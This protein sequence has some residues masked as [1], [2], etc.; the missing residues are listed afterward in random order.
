MTEHC[1]C[2]LAL[3]DAAKQVCTTALHLPSSLQV[4]EAFIAPAAAA[5]HAAGEAAPGQQ[6]QQQQRL[7]GSVAA[8]GDMGHTTWCCSVYHYDPTRRTGVWR[9]FSVILRRWLAG[10]GR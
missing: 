5:P 6:Q 3:A 10:L 7:E 8:E 1:V 4:P 9:T 2:C